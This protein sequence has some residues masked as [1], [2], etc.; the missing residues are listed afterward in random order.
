ME[1]EFTNRTSEMSDL[2]A[3]AR[4]GGLL[5]V[6]GRRRVGKTRLLTHWLK[7]RGGL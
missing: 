7:P 3:A 4:A 1:L 5:V 2:V 6:F